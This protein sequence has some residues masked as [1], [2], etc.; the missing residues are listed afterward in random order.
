MIAPGELFND[1]LKYI[2]A[3][4]PDALRVPEIA[5]VSFLTGGYQLGV[6]R[7]WEGGGIRNLFMD[8]AVFVSGVL[9]D[10]AA[11]VA[12]HGCNL[13]NLRVVTSFAVTISEFVAVLLA[14][15]FWLVAAFLRP[16]LLRVFGSCYI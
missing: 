3:S 5:Q 9:E 12:L 7:S 8:R 15:P 14:V 6:A 10:H 1:I 2:L 13:V 11:V 4:L 16:V